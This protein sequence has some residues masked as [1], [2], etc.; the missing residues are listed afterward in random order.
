ME[1]RRI[2]AC[3]HWARRTATD[4]P[5]V[6]VNRQEMRTLGRIGQP[7]SGGSYRPRRRLRAPRWVMGCVATVLVL[8]LWVAV[9]A[10]R[11]V[12]AVAPGQVATADVPARPDADERVSRSA[13]RSAPAAPF[14]TLDGLNLNLPH[15]APLTVAFHEASRAEALELLPLGTLLAN[16]NA[17]RF[18]APAD[19][20]GPEY[21]VLS[22]R[23][24]A[25]PPTS[26]VDIVV[27]LGDAV[28]APVDGTVTAVK[29]YPLYGRT[30]DWRVEI[31][32]AGR[33]DLTVVMIHLLKP[34][35]NVG[36]AVVA[37]ESSVGVARLL[38]FDSHVDY[39]SAERQPHVHLEVKAS[40]EAE[41]IDP[42]APALPADDADAHES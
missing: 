17:T 31:T 30:R 2:S 29:E 1:G 32:P 13:A 38:P 42:N 35:V 37:G 15:H 24:R 25:A 4:F 36:D 14:A 19:M 21:R 28:V 27:P 34:H 41:P 16:D 40:V 7:L 23:G 8:V 9:T 12:Q 33:P 5:R 6:I 11:Q 20:A 26:A 10:N 18:D 22:S 39:V 3:L